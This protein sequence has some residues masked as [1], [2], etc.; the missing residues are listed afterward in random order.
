MLILRQ[1]LRVFFIFAVFLFSGCE[2]RGLRM[3]TRILLGTYVEIIYLD[4]RAPEIAFEEISRVEGLL[5][6]YRPDSEISLLNAGGKKKVSAEVYALLSR[7]ADLSRLSSGAFDITVEPLVRLWGFRDRKFNVPS[8]G[9]IAGVLPSIGS[10]KIVFHPDDNMIEFSSEG[11]SVDLGGAGKGYALDC[12]AA[13]LAKSGIRD[14][15]LNAGGQIRCAGRKPGGEPWRIAI[16][17]PRGRGVLKEIQLEE[18]SIAT[19]GDYE[20]F[21]MA[22]EESGSDTG[23]AAKRYSHIIDPRS[24]YPADSG[25]ISVTIFAPDGLTADVLSTAV[26]VLG[27]ERGA[28]LLAKFPGCR[29]MDMEEIPH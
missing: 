19:S 4:P 8:A 5:S 23:R 21:F 24:G 28:A 2:S 22:G 7:C 10:E 3:E 27:K 17:D 6:K 15:L 20:Q 18:G 25:I 1:F 29:I 9:R 13:E 16:K 26:Y 11:M 12:A 14:F